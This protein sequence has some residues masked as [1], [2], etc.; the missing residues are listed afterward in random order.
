EGRLVLADCL[1]YAQDEIEEIDG[2]FDFATLTGA[3]VVGVG[4]Y[5]SISINR[6]PLWRG[7]SKH[8]L[9][10]LKINVYKPAAPDLVQWVFYCLFELIIS[11][12]KLLD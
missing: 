7:N 1:C 8:D 5:T 4:Q 12:V 11:G 3:C 2:I 6:I 10:F 9:I